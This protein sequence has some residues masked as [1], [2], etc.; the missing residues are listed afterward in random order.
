MLE[1][2]SAGRVVACPHMVTSRAE[3]RLSAVFEL[4]AS[5]ELVSLVL[6]RIHPQAAEAAAESA[7]HSRGEAGKDREL[8]EDELR[9]QMERLAIAY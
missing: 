6:N 1:Q 3:P 5:D 2:I 4:R 9:A 8:E 7:S